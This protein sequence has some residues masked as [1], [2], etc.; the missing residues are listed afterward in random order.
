VKQGVARG[1]RA[2][3]STIHA[4]TNATYGLEVQPFAIYAQR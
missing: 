2:R 3:D 1:G 4:E